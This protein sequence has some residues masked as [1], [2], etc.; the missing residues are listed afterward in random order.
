MEKI[1][2]LELPVLF[3]FPVNASPDECAGALK[4]YERDNQDTTRFRGYDYRV[5]DLEG[6]HTWRKACSGEVMV[7][8]GVQGTFWGNSWTLRPETITRDNE[9]DAIGIVFEGCFYVHHWVLC[10]ALPDKKLQEWEAYARVEKAKRLAM[11]R[12]QSFGEPLQLGF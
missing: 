7:T 9:W 2:A 10:D 5:K 8:A 6:I 1:T 4:A 11:A 3:Q 12:K